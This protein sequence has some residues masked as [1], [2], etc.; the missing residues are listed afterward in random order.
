[1]DGVMFGTMR[2][3]TGMSFGAIGNLSGISTVSKSLWNVEGTHTHTQFRQRPVRQHVIR[4]F[5]FEKLL[6]E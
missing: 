3:C 5:D 4:V 2:G 1:M 6:G